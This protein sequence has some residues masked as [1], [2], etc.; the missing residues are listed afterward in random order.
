[1]MAIAGLLGGCQAPG[2]LAL[3]GNGAELKAGAPAV[4]PPGKEAMLD[5][6]P[7]CEADAAATLSDGIDLRYAG[8]DPDDPDVCLVSWNGRMH[9]FLAGFWG[10]GRIRPASAAEREAIRSAMTGPVGTVASFND[11]RA[12][13]WGKVTVEHV[14]NPVL[15]LESGPRQTVLLRLVKHD[16]HGRAQVKAESLHWIDA[17]TGVALKTQTVTRF[18]DGQQSVATTWQ[19]ERFRET[20]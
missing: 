19:V 16:E 15:T 11:A 13:L 5:K 8:A 17:N 20:S 9:R 1:M 2:K 4:A 14:A 18:A 3:R 6:V 7:P 12:K 10:A